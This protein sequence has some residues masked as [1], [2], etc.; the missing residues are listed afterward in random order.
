M[1]DCDR[2]CEFG[3]EES[4]LHGG[5]PA[6]NDGDVLVLEEE[7]V[8]GCAP[9]D[10]AARQ[11]LLIFQAQLAVG[12]AGGDN[13][14][15]RSERLAGADSDLLDGAIEFQVGDVL[16]Q[17]FRTEALG[18]L[19]EGVHEIRSHD[20]FGETRVVFDVGGVHEFTAGLYGTGDQQRLQVGTRRV[21][22][23]RVTGRAGADD[24][25]VPHGRGGICAH[26]L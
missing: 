17:D 5:V 12:R 9:A 25:D 19:L 8:A 20:A 7:A 3:Q 18:L 2:L 10:P 13:D 11:T 6:A 23:C 22:S 26:C 15:L 1:D 16:K 24:D 21:D 4:F 14:G